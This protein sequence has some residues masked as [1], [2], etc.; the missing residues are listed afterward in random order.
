MRDEVE[1]PRRRRQA[2]PG[3]LHLRVQFWRKAV[4]TA[5]GEEKVPFRRALVEHLLQPPQKGRGAAKRR[6]YKATT[7]VRV[8][9]AV[10]GDLQL[11]LPGFGCRERPDRTRV[12]PRFLRRVR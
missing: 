11:P 6:P 3:F 8:R 5:Q 2:P 4:V 10:E 9:H 12:R 7:R 1:G